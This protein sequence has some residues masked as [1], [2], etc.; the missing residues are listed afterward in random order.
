MW[1]ICCEQLSH[2]D[3]AMAGLVK[4]GSSLS[5]LHHLLG[6]MDLMGALHPLLTLPSLLGFS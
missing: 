1:Y 2:D 6:L 4:Q 3:V 5:P